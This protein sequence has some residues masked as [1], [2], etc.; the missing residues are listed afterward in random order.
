MEKKTN[1]ALW[2]LLVIVIPLLFAASLS[3]I[4]LSLMGVNLIEKGKGYVAAVPVVAN[5]VETA[6]VKER[7]N[8][9]MV[10]ALESQL[11]TL[12]AEADKAEKELLQKEEIINQQKSDIAGLKK[13]LQQKED[14]DEQQKQAMDD[15]AEIY[16]TMPPGNAAKI[17]E[18]MKKE[19]AALIMT[20]LDADAQANILA[21][22]DPAVAANITKLLTE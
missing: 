5:L 12:Q 11:E 21:E 13:Q 19:E 6:D 16:G 15:V 9:E 2:F 14:K 10:A 7:S 4:I 8:K 18:S 22:M 20:R 17:F 1:K 3:V